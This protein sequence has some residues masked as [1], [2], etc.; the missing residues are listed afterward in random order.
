MLQTGVFPQ[1][2]AVSPQDEGFACR[3]DLASSHA[4]KAAKKYLRNGGIRLVLRLPSGADLSPLDI[5]VNPGL[6]RRL[7]GKDMSTHEKV[8][9]SG[10]R[11]LSEMSEAPE[12]KA[13]LKKCCRGINAGAWRPYCHQLPR[14]ELGGPS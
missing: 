7:R 4:A 10:A 14:E 2:A 1:V 3:R 5:F 6:K 13:S 9:G 12:F 11:A 8:I